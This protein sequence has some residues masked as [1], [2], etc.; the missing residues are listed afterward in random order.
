M[1]E[2]PTYQ[3]SDRQRISFSLDGIKIPMVVDGHK[4]VLYR[5]AQERLDRK[6]NEYRKL[7]VQ[8]AAMPQGIFVA[9]VAIDTAFRLEELLQERDDSEFDEKIRF[10]NQEIGFFLDEHSYAWSGEF[11]N[12]DWSL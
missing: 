4:E 12:E 6:L 10:L 8:E 5:R 3:I 9:M 11:L 7:Y 2:T 1:D